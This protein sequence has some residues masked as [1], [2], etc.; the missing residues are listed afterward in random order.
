MKDRLIAVLR[1][2][3]ERNG[4][5]KD[6]AN[7]VAELYDVVEQLRSL[8]AEPDA[9]ATSASNKQR[10]KSIPNDINKSARPPMEFMFITP[11]EKGI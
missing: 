8:E 7:L 6:V 9:I 1:A 2:A 5:Q 3:R 11:M 10:I 4:A